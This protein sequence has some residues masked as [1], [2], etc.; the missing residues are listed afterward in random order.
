MSTPI[1]PSFRPRLRRVSGR[2]LTAVAASLLF[3]G[4]ARAFG[5]PPPDP[6]TTAIGFIQHVV[7]GSPPCDT[8]PPRVCAGQPFVV[9]VS[10]ELP[11]PCYTFRGLDLVPTRAGNG[12]YPMLRAEFSVD[13]CGVACPLM[14]VP[15]MGRLELPPLAAGEAFLRLDHVTRTCPDSSAAEI[16]GRSYSFA[17]L[18]DCDSTPPEPPGLDSLVKNLTT[19]RVVP[20]NPCPGETLFL[21]LAENG[22][23]PCVDLVSLEY[24]SLTSPRAVVSWRPG[25]FEFAC[26]PETLRTAIGQYM[27]GFYLLNVPVD[28]HVLREPLPDTTVSYVKQVRFQVPLE[29]D[30]T[31]CVEPVLHARRNDFGCALEVLP[32]K[33]GSVTLHVSTP[34]PLGGLQGRL[35]C[36]EPFRVVGVRAPANAPL[37][38]VFW[39]SEGRSARYVLLA[40]GGTVVPAGFSPVLRVEIEADASATIGQTGGLVTPI[41]VASGPGGEAVPICDFPLGLIAPVLLCVASPADSCDANGDGRSDVRD[42]VLMTHCLWPRPAREPWDSAGVC[43]DCNGDGSFGFE[44]LVCCARHILRGPFLPRDSVVANDALRVSLDPVQDGGRLMVRVRISG[45]DGL[46]G[47]MLRL[48]YPADR[49]RAQLPVVFLDRATLATSEGWLPLIDPEQPGVVQ[50]GGL[51]IAETAS[52]ELEFLIEMVPTGTSQAGD[53][54]VAEGADLVAGDGTVLT[55]TAPLP[56]IRL[57]A[58]A[59]PEGPPTAVALGTARPNPFSSATTFTVSLPREADVELVVH[60]LAGRRVATLASGRLSAGRKDF[61]WSGAGARDGLYFVQLKVE[62]KVYSTRVAL[63]RNRR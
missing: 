58:P 14:Q 8:C 5:D 33:R 40:A 28:V 49:W 43:R 25:C 48:R 34:V 39:Q 7:I 16:L 21:E 46:A 38:H 1:S 51:R 12:L 18:A 15:F 60:D 30:S 56:E 45:A 20:E 35:E 52:G 62:G 37:Y 29:C 3:A 50:L 61:T 19:L 13:T 22:C 31:G 44:D 4:A 47:A 23:P 53:R 36:P 9:T 42:L 63:V 10:G 26:M 41:Q 2:I 54:L 32:G 57:D 59:P 55:P 6:D 27:P 24:D 11:S 17:V